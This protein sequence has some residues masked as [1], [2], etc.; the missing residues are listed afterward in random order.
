M[1]GNVGEWTFS[2]ADMEQF[3]RAYPERT[4]PIVRRRIY[5]GSHYLHT[6]FAAAYDWGHSYSQIHPHNCVGFRLVRELK[7]E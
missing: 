5:R 2:I 1:G 6:K 7:I 4:W 3:R